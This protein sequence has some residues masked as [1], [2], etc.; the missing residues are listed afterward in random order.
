MTDTP[1]PQDRAVEAAITAAV[2]DANPGAIVIGYCV[3]AETTVPGDADSTAYA[4][5][6]AP[7]QSIG[8]T[9]GLLAMGTNYHLRQL[10]DRT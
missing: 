7:G 9:L 5:N 10:G 2:Q 8:H 3:I 1:T 4:Y 6:N